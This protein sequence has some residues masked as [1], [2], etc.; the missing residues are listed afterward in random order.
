M[1]RRM[2]KFAPVSPQQVRGK[3]SR[4]SSRAAPR[5]AA[6]KAL[7][8]QIAARQVEGDSR[9]QSKG[10]SCS[11]SQK[12]PPRSAFR[13]IRDYR[14]AV[15]ARLAGYR[16]FRRQHP[17]PHRQLFRRR[18]GRVQSEH[19][20][21]LPAQQD[22]PGLRSQCQGLFSRRFQPWEQRDTLFR[23]GADVRSSAGRRQFS[24]DRQPERR[25]PAQRPV[26]QRRSCTEPITLRRWASLFSTTASP[27]S[28][29]LRSSQPAR[30]PRADRSRSS[31]SPQL[32]SPPPRT[33]PARSEPTTA[34]PSGGNKA[35]PK[36]GLASME[37]CGA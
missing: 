36:T 24:G 19:P 21:R 20:Q 15:G 33:A 3:G 2:S 31:L 22:R 4:G 37:G 34:L 12:R 17:Q 6:G 18:R 23:G 30:T 25:R 1:H 32:P 5:F 11:N 27:I 29:R 9:H 28:R 10:T 7:R 26:R 13:S 16:H 8:L 35:P 14:D